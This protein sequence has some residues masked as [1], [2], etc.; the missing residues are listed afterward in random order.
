M[1]KRIFIIAGEPSGDY[2]GS[3]LIKDI[4]DLTNNKSYELLCDYTE[5]QIAIIKA[6]GLL[7]YTKETN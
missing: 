7:A 5:R 1:H 3:N 2:L 4:K 6:G